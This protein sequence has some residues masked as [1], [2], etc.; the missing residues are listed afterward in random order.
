[1]NSLGPKPLRP[2]N[3]AQVD[4]NRNFDCPL[5]DECLMISGIDH[6]PSFSCISCPM[7]TTK[8]EKKFDELA[9]FGQIRL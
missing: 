4:R 5:Y 3:F 6:W 2:L 9:K 7:S 8:W 1:M